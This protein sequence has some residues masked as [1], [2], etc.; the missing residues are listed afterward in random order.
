MRLLVVTSVLALSV[1][2]ALACSQ[3]GS[4]EAS[5][6]ADLTS[7]DGG[8][9]TP[10]QKAS[11]ALQGAWATSDTL[12]IALIISQNTNDNTLSV[13]RDT[14]HKKAAGDPQGTGDRDVAN[15]SG[16]VTAVD[17]NGGGGT[18][19]LSQF[20]FDHGN[21]NREIETWKFTISGDSLTMTEQTDVFVNHP[22]Q[23]DGGGVDTVVDGGAGSTN[24]RAPL[25]LSRQP[26]FC[27]AGGDFDCSDQFQTGVFKTAMPDAC[28]DREDLCLFCGPKHQCNVKVPSTCELARDTCVDSIKT[29]EFSDPQQGTT[30][31]VTTIDSDGKTIDCNGSPHPGKSVCCLT[32]NNKND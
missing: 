22:F 31:E 6:G 8:V 19:V 21:A 16:T 25:T 28:K 11:K 5:S 14:P 1:A 4:D 3:G 9:E 17:S 23:S 18:I 30:G 2:T 15:L 10:I 7:S 32:F 20:T 13:N 26:S 27:G 24:L 12:P 29:C